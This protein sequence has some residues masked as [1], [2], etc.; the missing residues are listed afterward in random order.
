MAR[1][2]Y[3]NNEET[4]EKLQQL[5]DEIRLGSLYATDYQNTMGF[6]YH[7]VQ[8]FFDGYSDFLYELAQEDYEEGNLDFDP[9]HAE[10]TDIY[11]EYDN[12][13]TLENWYDITLGAD[14]PVIVFD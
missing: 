6:D 1:G 14:E 10:I 4:R 3:F 8:D 13:D 7:D 2:E 12:I 9:Y 5:R 11:D